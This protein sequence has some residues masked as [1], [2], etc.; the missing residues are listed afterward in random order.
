[1]RALQGGRRQATW[2]QSAEQ[3]QH[4]DEQM[5]K[6]AFGGFGGTI[7][8]AGAALVLA[9]MSLVMAPRST[10]T[11]VADPP[12]NQTYTGVKRCASCHFEQFMKWKKTRHAD[13]F[14]LL[15]A[16][17]EKDP[18]C[19]ECHTTGFGKPSGFKDKASSAAL[20]GVT[21]EN[22]HGPGSEHEKISQKFA[23]VKTLTPEQ[24]KQVRGSIW[25]MLPKN[26]CVEC[27]KVQ[28]H[29]DAQTPPAL[30]TKK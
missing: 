30:R 21:C 27:H 7:T 10:R 15:T 13:A 26:V 4:G 25:L 17:Y 5:R 20:V 1:M 8:L 14:K 11:A 16:K 19:V 6:V 22:C 12:E 28:A 2:Y 29:G 24:D 18:K 3:H 9:T 23:K